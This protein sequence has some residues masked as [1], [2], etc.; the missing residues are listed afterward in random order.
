MYYDEEVDNATELAERVKYYEKK[1]E[2]IKRIKKRT[3]GKGFFTACL[4]RGCI[5]LGMSEK[6]DFLFEEKDWDGNP[7]DESNRKPE[8]NSSYKNLIFN[9]SN[10]FLDRIKE[11]PK[12]DSETIV[13]YLRKEE[14]KQKEDNNLTY[15]SPYENLSSNSIN[16]HFNTG[17]KIKIPEV[18]IKQI[19]ERMENQNKEQK[20]LKNMSRNLYEKDNAKFN[21]NMSPKPFSS[22]FGYLSSREL[23]V[24]SET[25][26]YKL[27]ELW[28]GSYSHAEV[29]KISSDFLKSELRNS[30]PPATTLFPATKILGSP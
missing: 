5:R 17:Q 19:I 9:N 27:K 6:Y 11:M 12:I 25:C 28:K 29:M 7:V 8:Y 20:E 21:V 14:E 30:M 22:S 3:E 2:E 18:D 4:M 13:R 10:N 24:M 1:L 26:E 15:K 16:S 23:K